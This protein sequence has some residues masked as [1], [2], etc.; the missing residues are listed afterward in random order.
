[1]EK[2]DLLIFVIAMYLGM[3][4]VGNQILKKLTKINDVLLNIA[5]LIGDIKR[6]DK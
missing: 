6:E 5:N 3:G 1:M 4:I 2:T